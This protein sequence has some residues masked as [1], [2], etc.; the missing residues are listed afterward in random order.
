MG[1]KKRSA[2]N[3]ITAPRIVAYPVFYGINSPKEARKRIKEIKKN[4]GDGV[5]FFG[6]PE[7]ILWAALDEAKQQGLQTTMHHAQLDVTHAN[8]LT[9]SAHA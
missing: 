1:F 8:V 3:E 9:T 6:A 7:E 4:G 2:R 5:K